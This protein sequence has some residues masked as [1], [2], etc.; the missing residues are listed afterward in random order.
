MQVHP[1]MEIVPLFTQIFTCLLITIFK[2]IF[3]F[4][5]LLF[6]KLEE[7]WLIETLLKF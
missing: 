2:N 7:G 5:L 6:S 3:I 4:Y 1:E